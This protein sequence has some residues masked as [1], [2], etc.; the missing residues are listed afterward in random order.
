MA[1]NAGAVEVD[2][3]PNTTK[4]GAELQG[5]MNSL[6]KTLSTG[7][8][9]A[10][11]GIGAAAA[12][13]IVKSVDAVVDLARETK[14]L[15]R[16]TGQS[17]E[18]ASALIA[19]GAE[20]GVTT[21]QLTVGLGLFDKSIVNNS[22]N[23]LKYG[24]SLRDAQGQIKPFDTIL[25]EAADKFKTLP[26]AADQAAFAMNA[27][28]RSGKSLIPVLR[29]GS[30]GIKEL[31][32]QA[33]SL[34]VVLSQK[35]EDQALELS[36]A[37]RTFGE[38]V[39]GL[40]VSIGTAFVP[41]ARGFITTMTSIVES[42]TQLPSAVKTGALTF[43][44]L[45]GALAAVIRVG[46]GIQSIFGPLAKS[47]A[48]GVVAAAGYATALVS[49]AA[50]EGIAAAASLALE[51][52]LAFLTGPVGLIIQLVGVLGIALV[53]N[54][55][56]SASNKKAVADLTA[57]YALGT[58]AVNEYTKAQFRQQI[59]SEHVRDLQN[60]IK[61]DA[62][63]HV[64][65]LKL[66]ADA[67]KLAAS[68]GISYAAALKI[69]VGLQEQAT[70]TTVDLNKALTETQLGKLAAFVSNA[71]GALANFAAVSGQSTT[72]I[73]TDFDKITSGGST[74]ADVTKTI[75]DMKA[76]FADFKDSIAANLG[77]PGSALADFANKS[78]V[79]LGKAVQSLKTYTAQ[80]H[81]F[82]TDITEIQKRFGSSANDFINF[83]QQQGLSQLG[84]VDAVANGSKKTAKAF[85]DNWGKAKSAT[86]S[87]A[88][89]IASALGAVFQ[90]ILG[91]LTDLA[92]A[93]RGLPPLH[94]DNKQALSA[95]ESV[96]RVL[97]QLHDKSITLSVFERDRRGGGTALPASA[98]G[99][100]IPGSAAGTIIRAG[101][102]SKSEA[103]L[104][105]ET[106]R[107][108]DF[109]AKGLAKAAGSLGGVAPHSHGPQEFRGQ[110]ILVG[111]KAYIR[112]IAREEVDD[113]QAFQGA[114]GRMRR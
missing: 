47:L 81:S 33:K 109:L 111:D 18:S 9:N 17:A 15:Q 27:F 88:D 40:A 56:D 37:L 74:L 104:P 45:A 89:Q 82:G 25:G 64:D 75:T 102:N 35:T 98:Q 44:T 99:S 42:F 16:V 87:L 94:V 113:Q 54:A 12:A 69:V 70:G 84:L 110:L 66:Q 80:L 6:G 100:F 83:A 65:A 97:D 38:S 39:K 31:E 24:L 101:E 14:A 108:I 19:V 103:I 52:A 58:N 46:R 77:G 55:R 28:G 90:Q 36:V 107:G 71:S 105:L 72:T 21:A 3:I 95:I 106:Q 73:V 60:Q 85:I 13:G 78:K 63:A 92:R 76:A 114:I 96:K 4:F 34:G 10:L 67:S 91:K 59:G 22:K 62:Q 51:D 41:V 57:Q 1:I 2:V 61:N 112:G 5:K 49:L 53:Q 11:I 86:T 20:F 8:S 50:S 7:A 93:F 43:L 30:V 79:N 68:S 26:T 32:A 23:L 29:L 48:A